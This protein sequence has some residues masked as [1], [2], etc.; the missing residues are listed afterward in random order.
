MNVNKATAE[1]AIEFLPSEDQAEF[2]KR[3]Q[4]CNTPLSLEELHKDVLRRLKQSGTQQHK[5]SRPSAVK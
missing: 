5:G 2:R 1:R 4:R 3:L